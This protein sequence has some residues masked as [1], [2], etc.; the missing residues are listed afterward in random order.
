MLLLLLLSPAL[1]VPQQPSLV[2][3][4]DGRYFAVNAHLQPGQLFQSADGRF[5]SLASSPLQAVRETSG[6]AQEPLEA[7]PVT[8]SLQEEPAPPLTVSRRPATA[9]TFQIVA[10]P[11]V[12]PPASPFR[13]PA[14]LQ[15]AP[16]ATTVQQTATAKNV[17][18][19]VAQLALTPFVHPTALA[20]QPLQSAVPT[21]P[22][23]AGLLA[24][25]QPLLTSALSL[26]SPHSSPSSPLLQHPA[27][28]GQAARTPLLLS[29]PDGNVYTGYFSFPSAGSG[30]NFG[31][32]T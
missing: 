17:D 20:A 27:L 13:F 11:A 7:A 4:T 31:G 2:Q 16:R 29:A 14:R 15:P 28:L 19:T 32:Q 21:R 25:T 23:T 6:L 5:F 3:H 8:N 9:G 30:F 10:R 12:P 26:A 18:A 1:A 24:Q 22:R